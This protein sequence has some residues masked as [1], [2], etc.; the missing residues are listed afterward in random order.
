MVYSAVQ[1]RGRNVPAFFCSLLFFKTEEFPS[2][3]KRAWGVRR[4]AELS[5]QV[6]KIA[7]KRVF[8]ARQIGYKTDFRYAVIIHRGW[9]LSPL[10]QRGI[11]ASFRL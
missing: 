8:S 5:Q 3:E 10:Y 4:H 2:L 9:L 7:R 6:Q 1:G 11:F